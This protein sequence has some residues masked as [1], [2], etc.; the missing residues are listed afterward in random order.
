VREGREGKADELVEVKLSTADIW[1]RTNSC[2]Q[3]L[4]IVLPVRVRDRRREKGKER[5]G[6][7]KLPA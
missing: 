6:H 1:E 3:D 2:P 7:L 4:A 5:T